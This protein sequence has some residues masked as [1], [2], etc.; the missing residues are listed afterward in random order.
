MPEVATLED[1]MKKDLISTYLRSGFDDDDDLY[2]YVEHV[3][4]YTIPRHKFCPEHVAPWTFVSDMY[5]EKVFFA[6]AFGSRGSGKTMQMAL[7]N[8]LDMLYKQAGVEV[9]VAAATLDQS[10]RGYEYF[11]SMMDL[12]GLRDMV[13]DSIESK[14]TLTNGSKLQITAGTLKGLNGSHAQKVRVDEIEVMP[15][16]LLDESLAISMSK[17]DRSNGKMI[18]AQDCWG[19]TRKVSSGTV[20]R[21]LEEAESKRMAIYPYCIWESVEQCKRKCHGDPEWGN[22]PIWDKCQGKAHDC[23][24]WYPINDFILKA[25]NCSIGMFH[26]QFECLSPSGGEKVY[27]SHWDESIH[28]LSWL[29]GGKYRSFRSVF[30]EKEPPQSWRRVGG[31][32]FGANFAF[33]LFAIEPRY[34]IW[35]AYEEYFYNK[36]RLM[37]RHADEILKLPGIERIY[38]IFGDPSAKQ[39]IL[40]MNALLRKKLKRDVIMPGMNALLEGVDAMKKKLEVSP[41]NN[42]PGMYALDTCVEFRREM[43]EWEHGALPDGRVDLE[44]FQDGNDHMIDGGRYAVYTYPRTPSSRY[45]FAYVSGV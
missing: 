25:V 12:P 22:C 23:H 3:L 33:I 1:K 2:F 38:R 6:F 11:K 37:S 45:K 16:N 40:D 44:S 41:T 31:L 39:G 9:C 19:S 17:K 36:D 10:K 27:G 26:T 43:R 15:Y 28:V 42:L 7:L 29:E 14:T 18:H 30:G 34:G 32:D 13:V 20:S 5:W 4:G 8:H 24:G 21:V 35:I